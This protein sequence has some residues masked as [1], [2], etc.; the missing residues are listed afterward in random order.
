VKQL[1][2]EAFDRSQKEIHLAQVFIEVAPG[3]DTAEAS[4]KIQLAHKALKE[5]KDFSAVTQEFSND[6]A[7]RQ[8]SGDLGYITVFTLPHE[9]ETVAYTL[10]ENTFSAP[11]KTKMGYHIFKNIGERKPSGSLRIAQLL[12]A[13][14]PNANAAEENFAAKKVD[15]L[16]Q[17]LKQGVMFEELVV[18]TSND[19]SSSNNKGELPEFTT[20]TYSNAFEEVAFSLKNAGDISK[21]FKTS[22]GFH[23]LKLLEAKPVATDFNDGP[24]LVAI[25]EKINKDG[26]L[27]R[28][29]KQLI[30]K[31]LALIKYKPA[32]FKA[33]DLY[34]FTDTAL[35]KSN[36]VAL[37]GIT[38]NTLLFS[39]ARQNIKA[40]D[41]V[42][43][44][45]AAR[46]TPGQ[47][48][49]NTYLPLYR[50]FI[51]Q[52]A[53]E[54]YRNNLE[55]YNPDFAYQVKEFRDANLLFGIMERN[56]WGKANNDTTGLQQ[57]YNQHKAK[58]VWPASADA[59][60]ITCSNKKLAEEMQQKLKDSVSN[61]RQITDKENDI[62]AD[63]SRFELGQL[64][65]IDRTNF[66]DGLITAPVKSENDQTYTF[67]YVIKVYNE[68]GQRSFDDA[69]GMVIS[70]YQQVLE[71]RWIKELKKKYPVRVNEAV[72]T[73]IK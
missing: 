57:Y 39:F 38:E 60:M 47:Y 43:F 23:I 37:K 61:W 31:R 42:K 62:T 20:G 1:V 24:T 26:R 22:H 46:N 52:S 63:S 54:F 40:V 69:R 36:T 33:K 6:E 49:D 21:P 64:P 70:D 18:T 29:K 34:E 13:Y 12:V 35:V 2:K 5:G 28:A 8:T 73:S 4:R 48:P 41:W 11:V 16:Y 58:Y 44:V 55:L 30:P 45:R 53:D 19:L 14:P 66:T 68:R 17:L 71:E 7:T 10:R 25:T 67:N 3:A 15:S 59:I 72:F 51:D 50:E 56:V 32:V 27:D 65:V 9:L